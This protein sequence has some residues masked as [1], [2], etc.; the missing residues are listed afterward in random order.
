MS[1]IGKKV[2]IVPANVEVTIDDNNFAIVK[3]PKGQLQFKFS[4]LITIVKEENEITISRDSDKKENRSLHGTTRALLNN[5]IIGVSEG[6]TK[7]LEIN[8]VGYRATL[9]G[10]L[11][12]LTLGKSHLDE[13]P[14]PEGVTV[15]VPKNTQI[16]IKGCDKQ[17]VGEFAANIRALRVPEPYKGKG[18]RYKGERVVLKEGKTAKK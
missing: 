18:I 7:E 9:K 12:S 8:G 17:A 10:D 3:G 13:L 5:M 6:F 15:E 4:K 16:I 11:I 14:I 1:R 2:I